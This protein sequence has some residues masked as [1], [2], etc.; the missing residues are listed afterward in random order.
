MI[1]LIC[2]VTIINYIDRTALGVAAP[3]IKEGLGIDNQSYSLIVAAFQIA[4]TIGQPIMGFFIDVVGLKI[5]FAV[6]AIVWGLATMG[7]ALAGGWAGLA[8]ARAV[9]GFSEASVIP[10]GIK[11]ASKWFPQKERGIAAGVF[12]MG[13]SLGG[14]IAP[15]L[16]GACIIW[17]SW[18]MAFVV[19]GAL[20]LIAAAIWFF[21]YKEPHEAKR[22]SPEEREYILSGQEKHLKT[23]DGKPAIMDIL[24]QR[25]F[26]GIGI[27][28]FLA[29]PCWG[30]ISF[31]VPIFYAETL[32]FSI[33]EIA[34]FAWLP[35]LLADLGCLSAGFVARW[36]QA[37]GFSLLNARR[38]TFSIGAV[39]MTTIGFVSITKD[40]VIA[41]CLIAVGGFS[42]QLLSTVAATL[43]SDLFKENEVATVVG[44]AGACAWSGQ[45]LFNLFIGAFVTIIGWGPF[46]I[47][48][49]I[50]DVIGAVVL[51]T[52]LKER[53]DAVAIENT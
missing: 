7:H 49:A 27:A 15:P 22:L 35:F 52:F 24:K 21:C 42:H 18:Q 1:A 39:T 23:G 20:A 30:T 6:A 44:M 13:T 14:M 38:I 19:A 32:N 47:A 10:A 31:W 48:L 45:L 4:Y 25:N 46:F 26:W 40:P 34:M 16:I 2:F 50:F 11:T 36:L 53:D 43:G 17:H 8:A 33:K 37:K 51:W 3:T 9:M 28:R 29:D 41:V 12:N 5:G